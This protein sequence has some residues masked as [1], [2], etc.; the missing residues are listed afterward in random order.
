[1]QQNQFPVFSRAELDS[2]FASFTGMEGGNPEAALWVCDGA[3]L[4]TGMPLADTFQS[5]LT[6]PA[7]D[8]EFRQRHARTM[9]RWQTHYRIARVMAA[10][11]ASTLPP[12]RSPIDAQ[13]YFARHLYAPHGWDFKLNLYPLPDR[14]DAAQ[15]WTRTFGEQPELRSKAAYVRLCR[16]GG[17]FRFL[18]A[19]RRKYQPRVLLCLGE[20]YQRDYLRAFGFWGILPQ[21][22]ILQPA[23]RPWRLQVYQ[24]EGTALVL[25]PSFGGANGLSSDVLLDALGTMLSQW[26]RAEDFPACR[27]V[28]LDAAAASGTTALDRLVVRTASHGHSAARAL[29]LAVA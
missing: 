8:A 29:P 4:S 9:P 25:T 17:R 3:P 5:R 16:E 14:P 26:M 1:M 15:P 19:L 21:E 13:E 7:W 11:R 12:G 6:A 23:D 22:A 24:H 27:G 20:R 10:A 28:T 2:A 18:G